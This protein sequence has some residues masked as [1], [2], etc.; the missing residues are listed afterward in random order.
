MECQNIRC[1]FIAAAS[2][3]CTTVN[4]SKTFSQVH[5]YPHDTQGVWVVATD[6]YNI[7]VFRDINGIAKEPLHFPV[8]KKLLTHL[9]SKKDE[10]LTLSV[11]EGFAYIYLD[12][13]ES[14]CYQQEVDTNLHSNGLEAYYHCIR[15][16]EFSG[17]AHIVSIKPH[18]LERFR[19]A[20][21][22]AFGIKDRISFGLT[23][24]NFGDV[25]AFLVTDDKKDFFFIGV[26]MIQNYPR[27]VLDA[28]IIE[29]KTE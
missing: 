13:C 15:N 6:R 12:G 20:H 14:Y 18:I 3:F 17:T 4:E 8:D 22:T 24:I 5:I 16:V 26:E 10:T 19:K 29:P 1:E 23:Q 11:K 28:F 27:S 9:N 25:N 21:K 2:L 7:A